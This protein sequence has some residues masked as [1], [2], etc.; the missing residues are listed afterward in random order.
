MGQQ[1]KITISHRSDW[2]PARTKYYLT[3]M[4][5]LS[6]E[7]LLG[8]DERADWC[9][10]EKPR[11]CWPVVAVAVTLLQQS[12]IG[13]WC[14]PPVYDFCPP[15]SVWRCYPKNC[16]EFIGNRTQTAKPWR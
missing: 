1:D 15:M 6:V 7:R 12:I 5:E 10:N 9:T 13:A 16:S 4:K 14:T 8:Y 11:R 3:A 2:A